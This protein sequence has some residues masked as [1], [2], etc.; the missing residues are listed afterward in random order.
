MP[1]HAKYVDTNWTTCYTGVTPYLDQLQHRSAHPSS[2][3]ERHTTN[4][5]RVPQLFHGSHMPLNQVHDVHVVTDA[6]AVTRVVV[7]AKDAEEGPATLHHLLHVGHQV[8]GDA[9]LLL[10]N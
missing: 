8:V 1:G 10:P 7:A 5:G 6:C 9:L 2:Q 4:V 3:I